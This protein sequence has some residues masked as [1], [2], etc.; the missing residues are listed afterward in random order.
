MKNLSAMVNWRR[1]RFTGVSFRAEPSIENGIGRLNLPGNM[2]SALTVEKTNQEMFSLAGDRDNLLHR[3]DTALIKGE[4][5]VEEIK[6][7]FVEKQGYKA[8][9]SMYLRKTIANLIA[10]LGFGL[11]QFFEDM[12]RSLGRFVKEM[13]SLQEIVA[14]VDNP[15]YIIIRKSLFLSFVKQHDYHSVPEILGRNKNLAEYF[16]GQWNCKNSVKL[17]VSSV[18]L[19]VIIK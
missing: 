18:K 4:N 19:C 5:L 13:R 15:R 9:T 6:I 16:K 8:V 10:V 12:L 3:W 7:P 17:C 11:L 2:D 1:L 14:P